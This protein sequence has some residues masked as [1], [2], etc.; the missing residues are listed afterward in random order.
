MALLMALLLF[1]HLRGN[2]WKKAVL[3]ASGAKP[4]KDATV[5]QIALK[6]RKAMAKADVS[7]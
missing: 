6:C 5:P 4:Q 3:P 7:Q 2:G 1:N